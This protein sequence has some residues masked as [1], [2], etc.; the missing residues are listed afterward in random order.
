MDLGMDPDCTPAP[1]QTQT[2]SQTGPAVGQKQ[3][4]MGPHG[5]Q[6]MALEC[7]KPSRAKQGPKGPE[8]LKRGQHGP[9]MASRGPFDCPKGSKTTSGRV[10]LD[11]FRAR[12]APRAA[13]SPRPK[14]GPNG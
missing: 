5:D 3:V 6:K 14:T 12:C 2:A 8:W 13:R 7:L 10:V 4:Q 9:E 1:A 11:R